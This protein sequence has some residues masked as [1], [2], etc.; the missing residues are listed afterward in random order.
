MC[1]A[2]GQTSEEEKMIGF[3]FCPGFGFSIGIEEAF[4]GP[5]SQVCNDV[6]ID[7]AAWT[8]SDEDAFTCAD[9]Q[10]ENLCVLDG[11]KFP[12]HGHVANTA[13][14]ACGG[15]LRSVEEDCGS[16]TCSD[17]CTGEC[18]WSRNKNV[19]VSG[20][21]TSASEA[22]LGECGP[23]TCESILCSADC[24]GECGWSTPDAICKEGGRT[25]KK[26][27][28]ARLGVCANE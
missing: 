12:N 14:C 22:G 6:T 23:A 9:Y 13:C 11:N 17:D 1:V 28:K 5:V 19:C 8:D 24:S 10:T 16:I 15:G 18:G 26:E 27:R 21:K 2:G 4:R 7:G 20:G 25:T 3:K